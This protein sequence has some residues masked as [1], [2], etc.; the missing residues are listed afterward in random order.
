M[1]RKRTLKVNESDYTLLPFV[2]TPFLYEKTFEDIRA[3]SPESFIA[4]NQ[5]LLAVIEN[6][7]NGITIVTPERNVI[8]IN[9]KMRSWFQIS[10][11]SGKRKCYRI[12]H[13][14]QKKPCR[15]CPAEVCMKTKKAASVIHY[16]GPETGSANSMYMHIHTFP[17]LNDENEVIAFVEYAYNLTEQRL[18]S[19]QVSELKSRL[20]LLE[21]ENALLRRELDDDRM[22]AQELENI[23][24]ENMRN[25]V[26]PALDYL[27]TRVSPE[28]QKTV[29]N[30]IEESILPITKRRIARGINLSARELQIAAMIKEGQSSKQIADALCLTKKAVDYHR[31]NIRKKL[32]I[33][34]K[35]NL[36]AYLSAYL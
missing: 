28:E 31:A 33:D 27:G 11:N 7:P 5:S 3:V 21:S 36:Q 13:N 10:G 1:K 20:A 18:I 16:C 14:G 25:F 9:Q 30:L 15:E 35:D 26:K 6:V 4:D 8:Y 22:K 32:H 34:A 2:E 29:T 12:F 19:D 17:I 24:T 23:V